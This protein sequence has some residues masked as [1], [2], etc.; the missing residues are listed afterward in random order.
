MEQTRTDKSHQDVQDVIE[1][2]ELLSTVTYPRWVEIIISAE[3]QSEDD[4]E[5]LFDWA[6][7]GHGGPICPEQLT[8]ACDRC[9]ETSEGAECEACEGAGT[10]E[11][12][13]R[14]HYASAQETVNGM[15]A[16]EWGLRCRL[17]AVLALLETGDTVGGMAALRHELEGFEPL[18]PLG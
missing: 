13:G 9:A 2:S 7:G 16:W 18:L 15:S 1:Q 12:C 3:V 11:I 5:E 6:G 17:E 4:Y 14:E 10:F 8:V